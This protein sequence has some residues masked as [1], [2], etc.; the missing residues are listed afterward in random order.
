MLKLGVPLLG[1]RRCKRNWSMAFSA[2]QVLRALN[3]K[4]VT[5]NHIL[6][7]LL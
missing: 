5:A 7:K 4:L 1:V 2:L 3:G 6:E